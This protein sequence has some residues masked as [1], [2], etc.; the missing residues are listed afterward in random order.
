MTDTTTTHATRPGS[1]SQVLACNGYARRPGIWT[2]S[3]PDE[4]TCKR[5]IKR[6]IKLAVAA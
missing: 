6:A 2:T 1:R 5:C 3:T 4:V